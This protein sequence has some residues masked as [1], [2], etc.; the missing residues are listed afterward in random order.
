MTEQ[1]PEND[2]V[3][4]LHDGRIQTLYNTHLTSYV[5][6]INEASAHMQHVQNLALA[7]LLR[8]YPKS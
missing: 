2:D 8:H 5:F 1:P 3:A 6:P 7:L 4:L